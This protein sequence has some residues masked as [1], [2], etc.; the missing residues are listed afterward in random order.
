[1]EAPGPAVCAARLPPPSAAVRLDCQPGRAGTTLGPCTKGHLFH[2]RR[3]HSSGSDSAGWAEGTAQ[4]ATPQTAT[5]SNPNA[6]RLLPEELQE[7]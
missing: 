3:L 6:A 2:S 5:E 4:N 7:L 1:M